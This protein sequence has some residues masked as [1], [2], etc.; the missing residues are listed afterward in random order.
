MADYAAE[1]AAFAQAR[2]DEDEEAARGAIWQR[3]AWDGHLPHVDTAEP[4]PHP[5]LGDKP[6]R[7][8]NCYSTTGKVESEARHAAHI[9]RHDPARV[10]AEIAAKR[11]RLALYLEAREALN[12][13]LNAAP[14]KAL[15]ETPATAHSYSRER[16]TINTL[17]GRFTAYE[18]CVRLDVA[19]YSAHADYDPA[20]RID[21]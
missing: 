18:T 12:A 2:Y 19:A 7:V 6:A 15:D 5:L 21:G 9:A 16:I 17:T 10:L 13:A 4:V 3:W 14:A 1:L 20:W 11:K 8:A